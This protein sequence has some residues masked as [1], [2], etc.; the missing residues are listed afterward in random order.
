MPERSPPKRFERRL[1]VAVEARIEAARQRRCVVI[2]DRQDRGALR[3]QLHTAAR[4]RQLELHCL[5]TFRVRILED[6]DLDDTRLRVAVGEE[7]RDVHGLEVAVGR[8][9]S[10]DRRKGGTH[11]SAAAAR[12]SDGDGRRG[13]SFRSRVRGRAELQHTGAGIRSARQRRERDR[14]RIRIVQRHVGLPQSGRQ[15]QRAGPL[16]EGASKL[17]YAPADV[18]R[19][20]G[21]PPRRLCA[22][23]VALI[24]I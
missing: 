22:C 10:A 11:A 16:P 17:M 21:G 15:E 6:R 14:R 4:L 13:I 18:G 9:R 7:D 19:S 1:A 20:L 12:A 8:G 2:D 3:A 23:A 24:R 5:V